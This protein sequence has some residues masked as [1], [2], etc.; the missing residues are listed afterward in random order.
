MYFSMSDNLP[1]GEYALSELRQLR[2]HGNRIPKHCGERFPTKNGSGVVPCARMPRFHNAEL[3][4]WTCEHHR[5][6][7]A[8]VPFECSICMEPCAHAD[9]ECTTSC[10]HRFHSACMSQW[11]ETQSVP[12]ASS[13]HETRVSSCPLCRSVL[14]VTKTETHLN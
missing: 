1:S 4:Q 5:R 8:Y 11:V 13:N 12:Y 2:E 3:G 10:K 9:H 6:P 7:E 14:Y